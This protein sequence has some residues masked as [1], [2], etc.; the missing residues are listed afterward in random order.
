MAAEFDA[1][2]TSLS[3]PLLSSQLRLS[4][5][6]L[7]GRQAERRKGCTGAKAD[8][9]REAVHASSMSYPAFIMLSSFPVL[10]GNPPAV[11]WH[12]RHAR[13]NGMRGVV[14]MLG[15]FRLV[16]LP[17]VYMQL[18]EQDRSSGS[19]PSDAMSG[20]QTSCVSPSAP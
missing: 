3:R 13:L 11:Q 9:T 15:L 12:Q 20:R 16:E 2:A 17:S 5:H 4:G 8:A 14:L 19:T 18:D 7:G 10:T 1:R 6:A